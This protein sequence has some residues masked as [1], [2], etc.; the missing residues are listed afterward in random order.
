LATD[1]F[2]F[3]LYIYVITSAV[4]VSYH[5]FIALFPN[6]HAFP[7]TKKI[8]FSH[9]S[10]PLGIYFLREFATN[11]KKQVEASRDDYQLKTTY[12][13]EQLITAGG[14]KS[15]SGD[16]QTTQPMAPNGELNGVFSGLHYG[17]EQKK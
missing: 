17:I 6:A 12:K 7:K 5:A 1:H 10:M 11:A 4:G 15:A 2:C 16:G 14:D 3:F 13:F 8:V 9:P